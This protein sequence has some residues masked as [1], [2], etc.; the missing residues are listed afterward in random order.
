MAERAPHQYRPGPGFFPAISACSSPCSSP[1]DDL[2]FA[3]E[4]FVRSG[5][6]GIFVEGQLSCILITW[7]IVI[8]HLC[9]PHIRVSL[10]GPW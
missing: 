8:L 2:C 3:Q 9:C 7:W 1:G 6:G 5:D 4:L 10:P